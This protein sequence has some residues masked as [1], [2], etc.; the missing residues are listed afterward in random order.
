MIKAIHTWYDTVPEPKRF[1]LF[2]FGIACPFVLA[3][4]IGM[5]LESNVARFIAVGIV[6]ITGAFSVTRVRYIKSGR[7]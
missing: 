3:A 1:L 5:R 4:N 7:R 2:F 6:G